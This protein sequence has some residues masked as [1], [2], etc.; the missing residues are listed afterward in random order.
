[1]VTESIVVLVLTLMISYLYL[2]RGRRGTA[3]SVLPLCVLPVV[4]LLGYLLRD[5]LPTSILPAN[6]WG[7]LFVIVGLVVAGLLFGMIGSNIKKKPARRLYL[8]M[9]GGFTLIFGFAE[10][11]TVMKIL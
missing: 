3:L 4:S 7:V 2:R 1:M 10:I 5:R 11:L 8:L 6:M 9:C